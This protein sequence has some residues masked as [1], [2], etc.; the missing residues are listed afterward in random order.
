MILYVLK[1]QACSSK[2]IRILLSLF[3]KYKIVCLSIKYL[4]LKSTGKFFHK[5]SVHNNYELPI[6]QST[7]RCVYF[8]TNFN[9]CLLTPRQIKEKF[10]RKFGYACMHASDDNK[11]GEIEIK[12]IKNSQNNIIYKMTHVERENSLKDKG[13]FI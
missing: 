12:N 9:K 1:K 6:P 3:R 10:R 7:N 2:H 11:I 13:Y 5:V 4:E 8:I